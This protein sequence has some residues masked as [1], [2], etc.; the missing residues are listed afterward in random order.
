MA[1]Y[2]RVLSHISLFGHA[3]QNIWGAEITSLEYA[4]GSRVKRKSFNNDAGGASD[5]VTE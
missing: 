3:Q 5:L 4:V 2:S 1:I